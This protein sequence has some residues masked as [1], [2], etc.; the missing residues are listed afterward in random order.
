MLVLINEAR[1][2]FDIHEIEW[3]SKLQQLQA[4]SE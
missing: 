2:L 3:Y 4:Y 1:K